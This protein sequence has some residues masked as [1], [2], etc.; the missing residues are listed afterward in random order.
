MGVSIWG[1]VQLHP[2]DGWVLSEIG[3]LLKQNINSNGSFEGIDDLICNSYNIKPL[4]L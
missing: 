1:A 3:N 4:L 2:M